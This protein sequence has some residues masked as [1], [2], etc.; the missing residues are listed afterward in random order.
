MKKINIILFLALVVFASCVKNSSIDCSP[1]SVNVPTA[2]VDSLQAYLDSAGITAIKDPRGFFYSITT[3]GSGTK[4]SV[5]NT[6][7]V[8]YKGTFTNGVQFE[9]DSN[10]TYNLNALITGWQEGIPLIGSGG[11]IKLYIPPTLAYGNNQVGSIPPNSY[12][13]FDIDLLKVQ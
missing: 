13:I 1:V 2:E 5:C 9:T 10:V 8:N 11:S 12:L 6:V 3:P 7:T 4:P